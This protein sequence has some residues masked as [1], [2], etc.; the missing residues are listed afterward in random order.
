MLKVSFVCLCMIYVLHACT[1]VLAQS[2][3]AAAGTQ[4]SSGNHLRPSCACPRIYRPVCGSDGRSHANSCVASCAGVQV[5]DPNPQNPSNCNRIAILPPG[6]P[7]KGL[8]GSSTNSNGFGGLGRR[9]LNSLSQQPRQAGSFGGAGCACPRIYAPV[10]G[11]G[12]TGSRPA[13]H[14]CMQTRNHCYS[15]WPP[16]GLW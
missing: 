12:E 13:V 16:G 2:A 14:A 3:A 8:I 7:K 9:M 10:C 11:S 5:T 1:Y 4:L 6:Q 15:S